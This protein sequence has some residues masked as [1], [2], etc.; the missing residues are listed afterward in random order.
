[1][2]GRNRGQGGCMQWQ[3]RRAMF[4]QCVECTLQIASWYV[5][6]LLAADLPLSH[7]DGSCRTTTEA[8]TQLSRPSGLGSAAMAVCGLCN[9]PGLAADTGHDT[10]CHMTA[11]LNHQDY[12]AI[13]CQVC[14]WHPELGN[15][16]DTHPAGETASFPCS[17]AP[18]LG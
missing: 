3:P 2:A 18:A 17:A 7:V 16:S 15:S 13:N 11:Y 12:L 10:I 4:E 9:P 14:V 5:S 8:A 1:M 6:W